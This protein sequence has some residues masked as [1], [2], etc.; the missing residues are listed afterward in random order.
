MLDMCT[1][2]VDDTNDLL[3]EYADAPCNDLPM[4]FKSALETLYSNDTMLASEEYCVGNFDTAVTL[5][6]VNRDV[7]YRLMFGDL[8][9]LGQ[10]CDNQLRLYAY[11]PDEDESHEIYAYIKG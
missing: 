8:L 5:L 6:N 11:E 9:K 1:M 7:C 10:A 3:L 4:L 2:Y